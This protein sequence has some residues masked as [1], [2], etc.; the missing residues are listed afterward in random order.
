MYEYRYV[1]K[2]KKGPKIAS[3]TETE[4]NLVSFTSAQLRTDEPILSSR[5][6]IPGD[7]TKN[8]CTIP[9]R[10]GIPG[11]NTKN[12]FTIPWRTGIPGDNTKNLCS[13]PWRTGIHGDNTKNLCTIP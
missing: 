3:K 13:I 6:R 8:L 10:T 9:W 12:L 5:T 7:N 4:L 1:T 11:D 2:T